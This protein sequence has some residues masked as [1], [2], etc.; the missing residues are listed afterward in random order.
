MSRS[1]VHFTGQTEKN[2]SKSNYYMSFI[3]KLYSVCSVEGEGESI[4]G[5]LL[6]SPNPDPI[7]AQKISYSSTLF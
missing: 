5:V 1:M 4:R 6:D 2:S 3:Y 7:L